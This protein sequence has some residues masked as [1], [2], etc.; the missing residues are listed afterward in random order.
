MSKTPMSSTMR[1]L[2]LA[3]ALI[4][5]CAPL[6]VWAQN[7]DRGTAG[8]DVAEEEK[9]NL[10]PITESAQDRQMPTRMNAASA[11]PD[12][13]DSLSKNLT[14]PVVPVS[15]KL[16]KSKDRLQLRLSLTTKLTARDN[17][18]FRARDDSSP[19]SIVDT[20]DRLNYGVTLMRAGLNYAVA[21]NATVDMSFGHNGLWGGDALRDLNNE[22]MLFVDTLFFDWRVVKS[23]D[24]SV[25]ARFGRQYYS[26]GGAPKDFLFWD[27]VDGVTVDAKFGIGGRLKVL[28]VDALGTQTRPDE[29]DFGARQ[30]SISSPPV[31]FQGETNTFRLGAVYENTKLVEGLELRAFGFF[32]DIG[33]GRPGNSTGSDRVY[34]GALGNFVDNDYVWMAGARA[35]YLIVNTDTAKLGVMGEFARSGGIDRKDT[36]VGYY[37]ADTSGNAFGGALVGDLRFGKIVLTPSAQFF[38]ADGPRY[39]GDNGTMFS[40]GFVSFK[41]A[42]AGGVVIDDVAGWHPSSYVGSYRGVETTPQ[43][44]QRITGTQAINVGVGFGMLD[45]LKINLDLWHLSDTGSTNVAEGDI[46]TVGRDLPPGW[47]L[48]DLDAQQ[49]LGKALGTELD[50]GIAYAAS[51]QV[52]IFGQGGVFLPGEF[53][54]RE[55]TRSGGSALGSTDPQNFWVLTAG[56]SLNY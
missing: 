54:K 46:D 47:G 48:A 28:V 43:D 25:T 3:G 44:Q 40:H 30:T 19:Q 21:E 5:T 56:A 42:H 34:D 11:N 52:T 13:I 29:V 49:R 17:R 1:R 27:V 41:G 53:Y 26:I 20:D 22:N 8:D 7:D 24:T 12:T 14:R 51:P 31:N 18:D 23:G 16:D 39:T 50:L 55:I 9:K 35:S 6:P 33:A 37:D 10:T 36:R 2:L 15:S 32:A 38:R 4:F 45:T